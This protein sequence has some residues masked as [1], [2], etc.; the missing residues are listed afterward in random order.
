[1][2]TSESAAEA[3]RWSPIPGP[4]EARDW[5]KR[6]GEIPDLSI[7]WS[8]SAPDEGAYRTLLDILFA[9]RGGADAA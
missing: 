7:D 8:A 6:S 1:M 9:P 5:L 4:D 3:A 2:S